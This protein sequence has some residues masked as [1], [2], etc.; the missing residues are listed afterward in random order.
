MYKY[1]DSWVGP[2][3]QAE[4]TIAIIQCADISYM[5]AGT[6]SIKNKMETIW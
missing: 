2:P 4:L 6:N 1:V 3:V 5:T